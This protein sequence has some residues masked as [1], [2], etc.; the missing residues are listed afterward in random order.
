MKD[1][2]ERRQSLRR[3]PV[4]RIHRTAAVVF[5]HTEKSRPDFLDRNHVVVLPL[6]LLRD[7][8]RSIDFFVQHGFRS[9]ESLHVP[10]KFLGF[11]DRLFATLPRDY[12]PSQAPQGEHFRQLQEVTSWSAA[13]GNSGRT[14]VVSALLSLD[15]A[16]KCSEAWSSDGAFRSSSCFLAAA[17]SGRSFR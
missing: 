6:F 10:H 16:F 9:R 12:T 1:E 11:A 2:D 8:S 17:S 15:S 4:R 14:P 5:L 13:V 7:C 3:D